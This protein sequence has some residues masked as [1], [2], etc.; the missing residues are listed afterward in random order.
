MILQDVNKSIL[1]D[2][3]KKDLVVKFI[4]NSSH[5]F[6]NVTKTDLEFQ[7]IHSFRD[8]LSPSGTGSIHFERIELGLP[9]TNVMILFS[10]NEECGDVVINFPESEIRSGETKQMYERLSELL[11]YL[12]D[13]KKKYNIGVIRVGF[14]PASDHDTCILELNKEE[15]DLEQ[16]VNQ[17]LKSI[18]L[19]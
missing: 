7:N 5:F 2:L 3:I 4:I 17:F 18:L 15:H 19:A 9:L 13:V 12:L 10:F 11:S 6:D 8:L 16:E 1:D 14:E